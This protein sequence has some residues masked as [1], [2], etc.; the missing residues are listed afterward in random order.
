MRTK[1]IAVAGATGRLGRHL[2]E[3]LG[4][5]GHEVVRVSRADGVDL[6]TGDGLAEALRGVE[7]V[8]DAAN[9]PSS[10][11]DAATRFFTTVARK[12]QYDG[13]RAGVDRIVVVSIIGCDRFS[14]GY[15]AAKHAHELAALTGP[16][17]AQVIR[18]AQFHELVESL[19]DSDRSVGTARVRRLRTQPVAA[20]A[21]AE[22]LLE[23][24][25]VGGEPAEIAG[26]RPEWLPDLARLVAERRDDAELEIEEWSG[27][28]RELYEGG[29][30]L[31]G[32]DARLV[33]PTFA[34]WLDARALDDPFPTPT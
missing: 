12:L 32:G 19:L 16:V 13:A 3:L 8:V 28:E 24:V 26:P 34:D 5:Q 22:A 1:L 31:P 4:A 20:R 18:I 33:G 29:A 17:P 21:A 9:A 6:V 7:C 11:E 10:E 23:L 15:Y 25:A 27:A 30:L 14:A 2:V